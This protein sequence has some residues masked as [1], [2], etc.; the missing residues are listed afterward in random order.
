MESK[1]H[2]I[3]HQGWGSMTLMENFRKLITTLIKEMLLKKH[4][5]LDHMLDKMLSS[6]ISLYHQKLQKYI[7][8]VPRKR[9]KT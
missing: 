9:G 8:I 7:K 5:S 4:T 2:I 1:H 3:I 6:N